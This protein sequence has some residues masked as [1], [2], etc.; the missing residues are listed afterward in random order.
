MTVSKMTDSIIPKLN[1]EDE[2]TVRKTKMMYESPSIIPI[3][4]NFTPSH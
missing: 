4:S 3:L 2:P 1:L